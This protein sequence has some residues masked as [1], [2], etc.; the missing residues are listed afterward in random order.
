MRVQPLGAKH[1]GAARMLSRLQRCEL[2]ARLM[3]RATRRHF[4]TWIEGR[5]S[6]AVGPR[7]QS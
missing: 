7:L 4:P 5:L 2:N 1:K 6:C 3:F